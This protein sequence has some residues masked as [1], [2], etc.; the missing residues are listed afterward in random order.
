M[1]GVT[2]GMYGM[3]HVPSQNE[4]SP[5]NEDSQGEVLGMELADSIG[6][7]MC[8]EALELLV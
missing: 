5:Q 7:D 6:R 8:E 4:D 3:K 2:G 1:P